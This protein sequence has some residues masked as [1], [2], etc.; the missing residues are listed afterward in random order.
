MWYGVVGPGALVEAAAPVTKFALALWSGPLLMDQ[1]PS[2]GH[3]SKEGLRRGR[4]AMR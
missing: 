2:A 1:Q 4:R 3:G